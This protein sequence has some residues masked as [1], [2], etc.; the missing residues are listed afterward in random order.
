MLKV[1][2]VKNQGYI[3]MPPLKAGLSGSITDNIEGI[4]STVIFTCNA[5]DSGAVIHRSYSD[6]YINIGNLMALFDENVILIA[7]IALGE[8]FELP[9][10]KKIGKL[11]LRFEHTPTQGKEL[12]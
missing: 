6:K 11:I 12:H 7:E 4:Q 8:S 1:K 5:D 10:H 9:I 3:E 2:L